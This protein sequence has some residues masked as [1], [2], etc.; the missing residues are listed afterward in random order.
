MQA[1][2]AAGTVEIVYWDVLALYYN[3][4]DSTLQGDRHILSQQQNLMYA[5]AA[6]TFWM[7]PTYLVLGDLDEYLMTAKPTTVAEV[8]L[9][10]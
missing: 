9:D 6:L 5:H 3:P 2:V 1:M 4:L 8:R 7:T 10:A